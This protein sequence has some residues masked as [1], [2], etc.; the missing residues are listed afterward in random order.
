MHTK[1]MVAVKMKRKGTWL[2]TIK[3]AQTETLIQLVNRTNFNEFLQLHALFCLLFLNLQRGRNVDLMPSNIFT[4]R[5]YAKEKHTHDS[6]FS[7]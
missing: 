1:T 7:T 6:T 3:K 5:V 2:W 4:D